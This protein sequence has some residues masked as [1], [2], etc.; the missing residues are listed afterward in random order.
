MENAMA[1]TQ[2]PENVTAILRNYFQD[3]ATH[4]INQE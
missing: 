1:N 4:M 3:T 2:L